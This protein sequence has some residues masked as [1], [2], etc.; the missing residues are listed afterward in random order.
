MS[1]S[2]PNDRVY[3]GQPA[4]A[5]T[6]DR[7]AQLVSAGVQLLG[8]DGVAAVTMRAV[9]RLAKLSPRYFYESFA[10]RADLLTAVFD[11]TAESVGRVLSEALAAAPP[12][13]RAQTAAVFSA[14]AE[15]CDQDPRVARILLRETAADPTLRELARNR[16]PLVVRAIGEAL[17]DVAW[18]GTTDG[19]QVHLDISA[20]IGSVSNLFLD[21]TEGR[22]QVTSAELA[23]YCT[24]LV[25]DMVQRRPAVPDVTQDS[26]KS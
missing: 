4:D 19:N 17:A 5:R 7:R 1:I 21:W 14:F 20:L 2:E 22:L 8:D 9:T 12:D 26:H 18:S 13:A 24:D 10:T 25:S 15:L 16:A 3:A 6:G 11:H 23:A